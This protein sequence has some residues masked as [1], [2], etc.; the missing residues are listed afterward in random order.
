LRNFFYAPS[1]AWALSIIE[2]FF[3]MFLTL[4]SPSVGRDPS[5]GYFQKMLP[6]SKG[7]CKGYISAL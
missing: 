4:A 1:V 6:G 3:S 7:D 5:Q 2:V